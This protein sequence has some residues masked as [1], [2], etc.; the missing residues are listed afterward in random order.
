MKLTYWVAPIETD[1]PCYN[2]RQPTRKAVNAILAEMTP[3][4]R[5]DYGK[6]RKVVVEYN[7]AFDLVDRAL[8]EGG[9]EL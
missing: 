5:A 6:P 4:M 8:G 2:I 7:N 1:S 9:I 3:E